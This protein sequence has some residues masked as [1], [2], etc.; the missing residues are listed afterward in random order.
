MIWLMLGVVALASDIM[1]KT[2]PLETSPSVVIHDT[3]VSSCVHG[4]LALMK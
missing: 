3:L 2:T 4:Y 1:A